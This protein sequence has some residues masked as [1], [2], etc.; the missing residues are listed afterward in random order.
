MRTKKPKDYEGLV[1]RTTQMFAEQVGLEFDDMRQDLRLKV[2][3]AKQAYRSSRSSQSEEAFVYGCIA[4][5]VK[6]LKKMAGRKAKRV[7]IL[8]TQDFEG[9]DQTLDW[10]DFNYA[11]VSHD[12]V[13]GSVE[14]G[15]FVFPATVTERERSVLILLGLAL[16]RTEIADELGLSQWEVRASVGALRN[17]LRD[18]APTPEPVELPPT[19][20]EPQAV[21]A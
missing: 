16:T 8:H 11:S 7:T 4:N 12:E 19:V 13:F 2:V 1:F 9:E 10:F 6:D 20:A 3:V 21:A 17:K 18:W 5:Y 15:R 14:S